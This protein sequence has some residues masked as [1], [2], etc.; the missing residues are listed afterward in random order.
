MAGPTQ[1]RQLAPKVVCD[2]WLSV[3]GDV[4]VDHS[5]ADRQGGNEATAVRWWRKWCA[6]RG[7]SGVQMVG[8]FEP[9]SRKRVIEQLLSSIH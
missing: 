9:E 5:V 4:F 2:P 8:M 7:I 1:R 6:A 3:M